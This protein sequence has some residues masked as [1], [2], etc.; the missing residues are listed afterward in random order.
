[1]GAVYIRI[2]PW[3]KVE[4]FT[5]KEKGTPDYHVLWA[6]KHGRKFEDFL[7]CCLKICI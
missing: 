3:T 1:M 7:V 4:L 2:L 5:F 6:D